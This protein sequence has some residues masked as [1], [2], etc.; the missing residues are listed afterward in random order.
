MFEL[1][2][3]DGERKDVCVPWGDLSAGGEINRHQS[4]YLSENGALYIY[5]GDEANGIHGKIDRRTVDDPEYKK[6][7]NIYS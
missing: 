3:S 7:F 2:Y 6:C 1:Q 5:I 4:H